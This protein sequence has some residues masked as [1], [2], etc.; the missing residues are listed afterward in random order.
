[1]YSY[2]QNE[3]GNEVWKPVPTDKVSSLDSPMFVTIL[4][5]STPV[6][7]EMSKEDLAAV[8]YKGPFYVDF[9][10]AES[11]AST[12]AHVRTFLK[13][14]E[15]LGVFADQ[16]EIYASGGKGFHVIIPEEIF[17]TKPGKAGMTFL[18]QTYKEMAFELAVPS[19][20]LRVYTARKGRMFRM[21]NV[22]RLNNLYKVRISPEELENLTEEMYT[23]LCSEPRSDLDVTQNSPALAYGMLELFDRCRAKVLKSVASRKKAK[24]VTLPA[25][26]PSFD[27]ML[28]GEGIRE[29]AGFHPI[30]LQVAIVAHAKGMTEE[31][32]LDAAKGLCEN[33]ASDG[34]RYNT[35]QKRRQELARMFDYTSDN[36]CYEYSAPAVKSLLSHAAQDLSGLEVSASEVAEGIAEGRPEDGEFEHGGVTMTQQGV[37]AMSEFGPKKITAMAFNNVVELKSAATGDVSCIEADI[38]VAGRSQGRHTLE[39]DAFKSVNGINNLAMRQGQAF[40]G[41]DTQARGLYLRVIEKAR[42]AKTVMYVVSREGLDILKL[43]HHEDPDLREPFMIWADGKS[44][45]TEPRIA[46][47]DISFRFIGY[48]EPRGQFRT[49][50]A[51]AP[52]LVEWL[53]ADAANKEALRVFLRNLLTCQRP[54]IIGRLLGWTVACHYRMLFHKAYSKF[55]ILHI[56]G[57]AGMGKCLGKGT[58]V[59][60]SDGSVKP[61][62]D[63]VVGDRLLGPDGTVRNVLST[64]TG[65]E[66]LYK[67]IPN[68]GDSY[69]VNESHILSLKVSGKGSFTLPSGYKVDATKEVHNLELR[70]LLGAQ[71]ATDAKKVD[72]LKGWRAEALEFP[73]PKG[74]LPVDPYWLGAWLGD[75]KQD[76]VAIYKPSCNMTKWLHTYAETLGMKVKVYSADK[77]PGWAITGRTDNPLRKFIVQNM[78][79]SGKRIPEDYKTASIPDRL[80]LLAGLLDSDGHVEFGGYDWISKSK[81]LAEDFVFLCR[82]LGFNAHV[83]EQVK[84][85]KKLGFSATYYRVFVSGDCERI[86]CLDKIAPPRK[87]IKRHLVHGIKIEKLEVGDYYG[88]ELDGDKL[89]LLGDFTV[90]HNTEMVKLFSRLHYYK[91]EPKMLTPTTTV[92]A[93]GQ[94]IAG[95]SSIPMILD[96]FKPSELSPQNY[97]RFK[98]MLR[99]AYN[100]REVERGGGNRDSDD[101]R[102]LHKTNLSAPVCFIAEAAEDESALMERVVFTMMIKPPEIQM[103]KYKRAFDA[104]GNGHAMLGTVGKYM[105][106]QIV[107]RYSLEQL[108]ADFD[109]MWAKAR[110]DLMMHEELPD[111]MSA[112]EMRRRGGAKDRTV[113]NYT[114]AKFGLGKF[115][116][117]CKAI[118]GDEFA[119]LFKQMDD[120]VYDSMVEL[121]DNTIPEWLKV[122]NTMTDMS[123]LNEESPHFLKRGQDYEII[124]YDGK[125]A[126]EIYAR[127]CYF[128]YRSY[129]G[130]SRMKTLFHSEQSFVHAISAIPSS[131]GS[132]ITQELN[133]PGGSHIFDLE[134]LVRSGF[135]NFP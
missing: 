34:S 101:Y 54:M 19:L 126:L 32:F 69:V 5:V 133:A 38:L 93:V 4:S 10:A 79:V 7:D 117:L 18:P 124:N 49:D 81:L 20:D 41:S 77:C 123:V 21:A 2:Y 74:V 86:P 9:D 83:S 1:V 16:L 59:L 53:D 76:D 87:Q 132:N 70:K 84:G 112:E 109:P 71:N 33:H 46:A 105:A 36:P 121:Q 11:P 17:M 90:T 94:N 97:D 134:E 104:A 135:R 99:D 39:L 119:D 67:I 128:K 108:K 116:S 65:R 78:Q 73:T 115:A 66:Q 127:A 13:S 51:D 43:T 61:V 85:I 88:F 111:D 122:F 91:E 52:N 40:T 60:L 29:G 106:A 30:A 98:L 114:V 35:P 23:E 27:A 56:A 96:E 64:T 129:M 75:G 15:A 100:C 62:Q 103:A 37:F 110:K 12:A 125:D 72:R 118:F 31:Q 120:S 68:K 47:K 3:G 22:K 42:R 80:Q 82:S 55:P 26:L 8:K 24:P 58:L 57:S 25:E 102:A 107:K 89:F 95:S 48:P 50:L 6:G 113:Y 45:I 63:V 131:L 92:F 44:V 14:L 28:R 130:A